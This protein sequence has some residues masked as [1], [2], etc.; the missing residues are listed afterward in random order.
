MRRGE[1]LVGLAVALGAVGCQGASEEGTGYILLDREARAAGFAVEGAEG[2]LASVLPVELDTV[3]EIS[4]SGPTGKTTIVGARGELLHVRG[5]QG[6]I[7]SRELGGDVDADRVLLRGTEAVANELAVLLGG[8][9]LGEK[10]GAWGIQATEALQAAAQVTAPEGVLEILPSE[11]AQA[12][13]DSVPAGRQGSIAEAGVARAG[14]VADRGFS[15]AAIDGAVA[16]MRKLDLPAPVSCADPV[17]GTWMSQQYDSRYNDWYVFTMKVQRVPG[18]DTEL[19]G[20]IQAN[21]WDGGPA[22]AAPGACDGNFDH[23]VVGMKARGSIVGNRVDFGGTS[24]APERYLCRSAVS[25]WMGYNLD[26]FSGMVEG[27]DF[28]ALN[29]DGD[30]MVDQPT[31]FIRVACQ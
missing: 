12:D 27:S 26:Q 7:E 21:S 11:L 31:P 5:P 15:R 22:K 19:T 13:L 17:T 10:D 30:R 9:V 14:A 4:L 24:W 1:L 8:E 20:S 6:R 25:K 3:S 23:W 2:K 28:L 18:S 16:A 29:N